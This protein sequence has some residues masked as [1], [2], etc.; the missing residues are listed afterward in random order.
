MLTWV[1][2]FAKKGTTVHEPELTQEPPTP[3]TVIVEITWAWCV[4]AGMVPFFTRLLQRVNKLP[5]LTQ[6]GERG[7]G[8]QCRVLPMVPFF[9]NTGTQ[10]SIDFVNILRQS[11]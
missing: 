11:R 2:V 6:R 3:S 4:L 5:A 9:A 7:A 10:V 8:R 1:P